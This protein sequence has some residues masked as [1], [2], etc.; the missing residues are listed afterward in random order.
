MGEQWCFLQTHFL[1]LARKIL[2]EKFL[3]G[4]THGGKSVK[5]YCIYCVYTKITKLIIHYRWF[6]NFITACILLNSL[7]L[8]LYD[9]RD[10]EALTPLNNVLEQINQIFTYIFCGEALFKIIAMGFV[11]EQRSYLRESWNAVD[12]LIVIAG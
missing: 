11:L 5:I 1:F 10:R 8:A 2:S 6:S 9:Y 3:Y 12:F 7:C 4:F